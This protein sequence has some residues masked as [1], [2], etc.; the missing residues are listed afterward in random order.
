MKSVK[1]RWNSG[2]WNKSQ[3][4]CANMHERLLWA[5]DCADYKHHGIW[6]EIKTCFGTQA[7]SVCV[8]S[9]VGCWWW[10]CVLHLKGSADHSRA[11]IDCS[12]VSSSPLLCSAATSSPPPIHFSPMN[13]LGTYVLI[14]LRKTDA[15]CKYWTPSFMSVSLYTYIY[16]SVLGVGIGKEWYDTYHITLVTIR[17]YRDT[18]RY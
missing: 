11:P 2:L 9:N 10:W 6:L 17:L 15:T 12:M 7:T 16:M 8:D 13:T 4:Q 18:L 1:S 14:K 3:L 5:A